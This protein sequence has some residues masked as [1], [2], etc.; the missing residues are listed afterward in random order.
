MQQD[1][2]DEQYDVARAINDISKAIAKHELN[3]P[4]PS[5]FSQSHFGCSVLH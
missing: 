5:E 4:V 1:H 2:L 3:K